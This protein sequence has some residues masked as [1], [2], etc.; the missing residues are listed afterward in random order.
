MQ[1][2]A[3]LFP[4]RITELERLLLGRTNIYIDYANVL[5]W[6]KKLGWRIDLKRLYQ[7]LSSF[8]QAQQLLADGKRVVICAAPK[9]ISLELGHSGA[10]FFDISK[11]RD[12]ICYAK[13]MQIAIKTKHEAKR[14][15]Y[16]GPSAGK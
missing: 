1:Q 8:S 3:Q 10:E 6:S 15:P 7:F 16:V 9:R 2:L 12:L 13:E 14:T 11:I 5:H 4:Q